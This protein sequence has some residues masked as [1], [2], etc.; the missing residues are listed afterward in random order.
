MLW[1]IPNLDYIIVDD[2]KF[3]KLNIFRYL[4]VFVKRNNQHAR[5]DSQ[6]NNQKKYMLFKYNAVPKIKIIVN[7]Y[8][9]N[10]IVP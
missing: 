2:Y 3:E 9:I 8:R 7:Y 5:E 6:T 4:C 10:R 1:R